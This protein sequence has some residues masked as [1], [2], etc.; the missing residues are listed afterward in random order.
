MRSS[1]A[2]ALA[3]RG[4]CRYHIVKRLRDQLA[5]TTRRIPRFPDITGR[6]GGVMASPERPVCGGEMRSDASAFPCSGAAATG[7]GWCRV[8]CTRRK[9]SER[10]SSKINA[11]AA[12]FIEKPP[13]CPSSAQCLVQTQQR[14]QARQFVFTVLF[15]L[16]VQNSLRFEHGD[17]LG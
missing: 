12:H 8:R 14:L 6:G 15:A 4:S 11:H 2:M 9:R 16:R 3:R 10:R 17:V 1:A 7:Q 5:P 13:Q